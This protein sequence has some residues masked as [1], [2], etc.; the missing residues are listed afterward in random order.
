[1]A[2]DDGQGD[3]PTC[4]RGRPRAFCAEAALDAALGVFWQHGY[5][6]TSLSD[7]TA[8]MGINR[9]SL[10]AAFGN[11]ERLF[12]AA[13]D[14]YQCRAGAAISAALDAPTARAG[15]E[16]LLRTTADTLTGGGP[17]AGC[18]LV[19]STMS[20]GP[21]AKAIQDEVAARRRASSAP[22]IGG[23]LDRAVAAGE[24]PA[25]TDTAAVAAF[26]ATVLQG[27]SVQAA[28]GVGRPELHRV[29]D[30]AMRAWP[31]AGK[32]KA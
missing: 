16:R 18:F 15:V 32:I 25:G 5:E 22:A 9:P 3:R 30:V 4:R 21:A 10:Y 20:C 14:R 11:K 28:S 2:T 24:L 8:A 29:I 1:M 12:R 17:A 7:L 13:M 23:R 27:L 31:G 6:G 19:V 26:V